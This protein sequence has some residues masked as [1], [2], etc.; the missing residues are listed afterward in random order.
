MLTDEKAAAI[1]A[2]F[3]TKPANLAARSAAILLAS[4]TSPKKEEREWAKREIRALALEGQEIQARDE[5]AA[6]LAGFANRGE[7]LA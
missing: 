4:M 2:A 6:Q 1:A 5:L 7:P 3:A